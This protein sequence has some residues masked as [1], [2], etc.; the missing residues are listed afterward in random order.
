MKY[1]IKLLVSVS[2][3]DMNDKPNKKEALKIAKEC[4]TSRSQ[5][6]MITVK[7]IKATEIKS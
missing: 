5:L 3:D 1:I 4:V 7:P 2:I 6:G